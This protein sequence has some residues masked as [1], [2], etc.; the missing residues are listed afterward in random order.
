MIRINIDPKQ[1]AE[2]ERLLSNTSTRF[3]G[4]IQTVLNFTSKTIASLVAKELYKILPLKQKTLK[5]IIK[6]KQK[7]TK[8]RLS[9]IV[10]IGHGYRIPLRLHNPTRAKEGVKVKMRKHAEKVLVPGAF[11][12]KQLGRNVYRRTT[13][14]RLPIEQLFGPA[15]GE[16]YKELDIEKR[17]T[18]EADQ[19]LRNKMKERIRYL[20]LK[21]QGVI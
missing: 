21:T 8:Q 20:T 1:A 7:A 2:L 3:P 18:T 6:Q 9:T 5:K 19:I 13:K 10:N 16:Y 14:K 12:S 11:I 17:F 15:P 4:T